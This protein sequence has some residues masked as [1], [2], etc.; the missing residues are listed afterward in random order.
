MIS[1]NN[2][3]AVMQ[4]DGNFALYDASEFCTN[5][6]LWS[7]KTDNSSCKRPFYVTLN[8]GSLVMFDENA[9]LVWSSNTRGQGIPNY[10]LKLEG[11]N[12]FNFLY[13]NYLNFFFNFKMTDI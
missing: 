4:F 10:Y 12:I 2:F 3:Y 11:F 7:S 5:N 6:L 13:F 1:N 8:E 9:K